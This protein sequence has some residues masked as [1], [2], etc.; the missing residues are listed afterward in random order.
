[1]KSENKNSYF[2]V[3]DMTNPCYCLPTLEF[4]LVFRI[5]KQVHVFVK[6]AFYVL[7]LITKQTLNIL[8]DDYL[9]SS[10][11]HL[12]KDCLTS[13]SYVRIYPVGVRGLTKLV[14]LNVNLS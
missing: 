14:L 6:I 4:D 9:F 3:C 5:E 10:Y 8:A 1:M 7:S 12:K 13:I 2:R 11:F